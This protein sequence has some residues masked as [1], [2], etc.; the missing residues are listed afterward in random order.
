MNE[1]RGLSSAEA[2]LRLDQYGPNE[3]TPGAK[4]NS[5]LVFLSHFTNPLV[6]I[7]LLASIVSA[8]VGEAANA[9][10]IA[11]I[12]LLSVTLDYLQEWRS[13]KAA[14]RLR[15]SVALRA[16]VI[17]DGQSHTVPAGELVPGDLVQLTVGDLVPADGRILQ[18]KDFFVDQ[19]AFTGES[20]PVEKTAGTTDD[21]EHQV[22]L[23]TNV[24]GGEAL[25]TVTRTGAT[26]EFSHIARS[27]AAA[28]PETEFER[29][30]RGFSL[31]VTRVVLL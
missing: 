30:A 18:A 15:A 5:L 25:A 3:I 24:T 2:A 21:K 23:G 31:F 12:I 14:E 26:T 10:I 13:N 20:F 1:P 29:G 9:A 8:F 7:L 11:V 16:N 27:L 17:R 22:W 19:A 6:L 4:R 28:P